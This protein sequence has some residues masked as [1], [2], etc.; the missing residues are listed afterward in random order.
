MGLMA[1]GL[2]KVMAK[3]RWIV[4]A[5]RKLPT[6]TV[7]TYWQGP[8]R[9]WGTTSGPLD[10]AAEW[11]TKHAAETA[12]RKVYGRPQVW[13]ARGYEPIRYADAASE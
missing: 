6:G 5:T 7:V 3:K 4:R 12:L 13:R 2:R 9:G 10:E 11:T 8:A 1:G